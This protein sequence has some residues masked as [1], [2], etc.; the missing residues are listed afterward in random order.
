MVWNPS[1]PWHHYRCTMSTS[2]HKLPASKV[3]AEW[4]CEYYWILVF[5]KYPQI[6][7]VNPWYFNTKLL[8]NQP[9]CWIILLSHSVNLVQSIKDFVLGI[10]FDETW[11]K[12]WCF[13]IFGLQPYR[14]YVLPAHN[15]NLLFRDTRLTGSPYK[16]QVSS[17]CYPCL[18]FED[19][20]S[21]IIYSFGRT[22]SLELISS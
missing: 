19:S 14:R 17:N 8:V 7:G 2:G 16:Q 13:R 6:D 4:K 21:N 11:L 18:Q 5:S 3:V 15:L 12:I 10:V 1:L 9:L 20:S 22:P